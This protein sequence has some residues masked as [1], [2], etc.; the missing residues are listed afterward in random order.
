MQDKKKIAEKKKAEAAKKKAA[1]EKRSVLLPEFMRMNAAI[2][3]AIKG[4]IAGKITQKAYATRIGHAETSFSV[5]LGENKRG[6]VWPLP[7]LFAISK[8]EGVSLSSI[9][10]AAEDIIEGRP[11]PLPGE[12]RVGKAPARS[13]ERLQKLLYLFE[14]IDEDDPDF[15]LL[16]RVCALRDVQAF[17]PEFCELYYSGRIDDQ[18][19]LRILGEA[20]RYQSSGQDDPPPPICAALQRYGK[21]VGWQE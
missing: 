1:E 9:F 4:V 11:N 18:E 12:I 17:A 6:L 5:L 14:G 16:C 10:R 19:A 3:A 21:T 8:E 2:S 7:V 15:L 13:P 20:S